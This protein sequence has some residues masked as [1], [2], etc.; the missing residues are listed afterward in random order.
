MKR[1]EVEPSTKRVNRLSPNPDSLKVIF[2]YR[3]LAAK[4]K[5]LKV[6]VNKN[7]KEILNSFREL[8]EFELIDFS[9]DLF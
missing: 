7:F 1:T 2:S 4:C 6:A 8:A 5:L 9:P 3:L